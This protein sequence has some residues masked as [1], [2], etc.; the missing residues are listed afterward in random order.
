M[1]SD[2]RELNF[3]G[4]RRNLDSARYEE[5]DIE[6]ERVWVDGVF[7]VALVWGRLY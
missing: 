4:D 6:S 5:I 1:P 3:K 2:V 7:I